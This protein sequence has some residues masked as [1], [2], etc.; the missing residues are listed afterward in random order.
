M[1]VPATKGQL[2][3]K[4]EDMQIGDYIAVNV[5]PGGGY[6]L[7]TGGLPE[8][9][10]SGLVNN[11]S[12][13]QY[14][15]Y[16]L[17]ADKG[18]LISDR[19]WLH[20][21]SWDS[22]NAFS[23]FDSGPVIFL[24]GSDLTPV[25]TGD[26]PTR[27]KTNYQQNT[28]IWK[29]FDNSAG[30]NFDLSPPGGIFANGWFTIDLLSATRFSRISFDSVAG[31]AQYSTLYFELQGSN[32]DVTYTPIAIYNNLNTSKTTHDLDFPPVTYRYI[33]IVGYRCGGASYAW[34]VAMRLMIGT[35]GVIRALTGGTAHL[36]VNGDSTVTATGLGCWPPN[37]EW[38]KY[39]AGSTLQGKIVAG[40][41]AV[42]HHS[43]LASWMQETPA[44]GVKDIGGVVMTNTARMIRGGG[45]SVRRAS[46]VVSTTKSASVGQRI[47]FEY[48]EV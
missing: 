8:V 28:P 27:I 25:F 39:V 26:V 33:K 4:I 19:A 14:F 35:A 37:N 9:P 41:D 5:V 29:A 34:A 3:T 17:K 22:Y 38:D 32:D 12:A 16:M 44:P 40:D 2:R 47:V 18:L 7:G 20:T 11:A 45:G 1:P 24:G 10:L 23:R 46:A 6:L 48:R 42:W 21:E 15:W 13:Y 36:D 43:N 30:T 31:Q